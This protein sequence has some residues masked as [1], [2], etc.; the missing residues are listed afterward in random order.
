MTQDMVAI[1]D[2]QFHG[3]PIIVDLSYQLIFVGSIWSKPFLTAQADKLETALKAALQDTT[4]NSVFDQYLA[5]GQTGPATATPAGDRGIVSMDWQACLTR[6]DLHAVAQ[7]LLTNGRLPRA[8]QEN[9]ALALILPPGTVLL[10]P[11]D[12]VP[13]STRG[14]AS[15]HG[16]FHLTDKGNPVQVHFCAAVWSDGSN[17][18]SVPAFQD[19]PAWLPWE[20]TCAALYH[21]LAELRT[22]Q[23]IDDAPDDGGA[24][25][26]GRLGW[27]VFHNNIWI[28]LPDLPILWTDEL[29]QKVFCKGTVGGVENVPIQV[30]WSKR[31]MAPHV[32]PTFIAQMH[33]AFRYKA[34]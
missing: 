16:T 18:V 10:D 11:R 1:P 12:P 22:N 33:R 24:P 31:D 19:H 20:N 13:S 15:I 23:N 32:P 2:L 9:F 29:P 3:C 34:V 28:E 8:G 5:P 7:Q 4:L 30:L 26:A 14:L 21:E 17:G 6:D 27:T 25:P